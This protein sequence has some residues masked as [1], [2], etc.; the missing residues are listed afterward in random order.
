MNEIGSRQKGKMEYPFGGGDKTRI[1]PV[2]SYDDEVAAHINDGSDF[3]AVWPDIPGGVSEEAIRNIE[4][5]RP[6]EQNSKLDQWPN[7]D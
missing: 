1:I 2:E 4:E 5:H 3:L 6:V 7:P